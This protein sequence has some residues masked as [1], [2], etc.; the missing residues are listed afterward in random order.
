MVSKMLIDKSKCIDVHSNYCTE[1]ND[2]T[3]TVIKKSS[4]KI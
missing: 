1:E 4:V 3:A 2:E